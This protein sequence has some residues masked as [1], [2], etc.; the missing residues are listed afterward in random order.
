MTP[1]TFRC[2]QCRKQVSVIGRRIR[3]VRGHRA[4]V[5]AGCAAVIDS[6]KANL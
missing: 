3:L 4:Y 5:G 6:R 2:A 1:Q